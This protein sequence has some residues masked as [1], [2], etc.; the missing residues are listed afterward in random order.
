MAPPLV[1]ASASPRRRDLLVQIGITP[2]L[3]DPADIDETPAKAERP[4]RYAERMAAQKAA[5][6]HARHPGAIILAADTVV[7]AG[8]RILP[9]AE[10]ADAVAMCLKLL[11]GR[12]HLVLSAVTLVDSA[13]IARHRLARSVVAFAP[14]TPQQI[15]SYVA[16][17]EGIG[18]AGGYGIQGR[19]AAHVRWMS[20]SYSAIVGLPLF[21]TSALLASAGIVGATGPTPA[22]HG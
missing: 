14:L 10:D 8:Q 18:K 16:S 5:A 13:G 9:K 12:R 3:I 1:L 20:G 2:A 6:A 15:A 22:D 4:D 21:E 7:A 19:M 17:G 11:S